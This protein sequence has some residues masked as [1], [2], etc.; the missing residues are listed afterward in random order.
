M[1]Q[2]A[3]DELRR[4]RPT[5][6]LTEFLQWE[7]VR[8]LVDGGQVSDANLKEIVAEVLGDGEAK[9]KAGKV[10]QQ[11]DFEQFYTMLT[12]I[13]EAAEGEVVETPGGFVKAGKEG[14]AGAR[15]EVVDDSDDDDVEEDGDEELD[16]ADLRE[17][18]QDMFDGLLRTSSS[19]A[20][21]KGVKAKGGELKTITLAALYEW[22][23]AKEMIE[24]EIVTKEELAAMVKVI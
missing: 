16:E 13:D 18:A 4:G 12:M 2:E 22:E 5:L 23:Y 24:D 10:Q 9:K 8:E 7:D 14:V 19:G 6:P 15:V 20:S 17:L 11:L 1:A 21:K 3:F